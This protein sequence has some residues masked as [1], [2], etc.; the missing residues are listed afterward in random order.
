MTWGFHS[1]RLVIQVNRGVAWAASRISDFIFQCI[2]QPLRS[3]AMGLV[4]DSGRAQI[5][6]SH[7]Y[8]AKCK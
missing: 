5:K 4:G 2:V 8:Y 6:L 7:T 1:F 3:K